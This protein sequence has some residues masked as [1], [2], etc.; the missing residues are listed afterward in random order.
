LKL[1]YE[2][3]MAGKTLEELESQIWDE[4]KLD[5]SLVA[6]CQRL[7]KKPI[8]EFTVEDLRIM[9]GQNIGLAHL[10]PRAIDVLDH[11]PLA[12]GDFYAGDLLAN[13]IGCSEW[14]QSRPDLLRRLIVIAQRALSELGESDEKLLGLLQSF[15]A[16][17]S[18]R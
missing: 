2:A 13:V 6:T 8:D 11:H 17:N 5:S 1:T 3:W 18:D 4:P 9:V 12:E 7:R 14:F 16:R 10:L 15:V